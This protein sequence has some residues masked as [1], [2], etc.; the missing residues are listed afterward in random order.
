MSEQRVYAPNGVYV[1]SVE[2]FNKL[3]GHHIFKGFIFARSRK[4]AAHKL[5]SINLRQARFFGKVFIRNLMADRKN[6]TR[7]KRL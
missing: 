4:E 2:Q 7:L 3:K 1:F 5:T 6:N